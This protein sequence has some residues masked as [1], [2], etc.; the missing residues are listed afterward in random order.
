MKT[1]Y[2]KLNPAIH[3]SIQVDLKKYPHSTGALVEALKKANDWS[4]L[5][6]CDIQTIINHSHYSFYEI[7]MKD[8][9]WGDKFLINDEETENA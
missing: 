5:F 8:I 9:L 1:I 7:S 3:M 2:D 4:Q 6:M